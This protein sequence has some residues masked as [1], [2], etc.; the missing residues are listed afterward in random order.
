MLNQTILDVVRVTE[1]LR[2]FNVP[3]TRIASQIALAL[4]SRGKILACGNGGSAA[5]AA[6]FATEFVSRFMHER[7][8]YPAIPLAADGGF[9]TALGNDYSFDQVFERQVDAFGLP[10]DVLMGFTTSG[11]SQNIRR[12][13]I[14]GKK[15]GMFTVALLG[16]DGGVCAGIAD[17]EIIVPSDRTPR[18]QEAHKV[19]FHVICEL[20][21]MELAKA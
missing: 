15:N 17:V 1:S 7:R 21:E 8:P 20:V 14:A 19:L 2:A 6:H 18:I 10:G 3:V 12:A 9:L 16:K 5:D 11:Q 13:L 4:T